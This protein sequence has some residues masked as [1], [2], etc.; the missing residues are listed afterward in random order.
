MFWPGKTPWPRN[1]SWFPV[2]V[3]PDVDPVRG[4]AGHLRDHGPRVARVRDVLHH[5]LGEVEGHVGGLRLDDGRL[6][7]DRDRLLE[8]RDAQFGI[9]GERRV[10]GDADALVD[11]LAEPAEREGDL[12]HAGRNVRE[13][14]RPVT[15]GHRAPGSA[16]DVLP[17][18]RHDGSGKHAGRGVGDPALQG[19]RDLLGGERQ[20]KEQGSEQEK[21][22]SHGNLP[23]G[24]ESRAP[25]NPTP[26]VGYIRSAGRASNAETAGTALGAPASGRHRPPRG[27]RNRTPCLEAGNGS[28][29][30]S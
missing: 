16:E 11:L 18:D 13:A 2:S 6:P 29:H 24:S 20:G 23:Q 10:R 9:E 14:V 4:H 21:K 1:A 8:R 25:E 3:P 12:V 30:P 22:T 19:A 5:F 26:P 28:A 17:G 27:G 7:G 15:G